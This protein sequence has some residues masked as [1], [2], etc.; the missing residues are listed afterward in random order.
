MIRSS[1]GRVPEA[2][3]LFYDELANVIEKKELDPKIEV[4][5]IHHVDPTALLGTL[6]LPLQLVL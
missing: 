4:G 2:A 6:K 3:A 1:I 5:W